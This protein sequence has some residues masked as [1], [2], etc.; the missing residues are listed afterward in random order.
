[1][2]KNV[3]ALS[4]TAAIAGFAGNALAITGDYAGAASAMAVSPGGVG[5]NL[6]VPYFSAQNG[7]D[8]YLNITN[9]DTVNGK[10]VKVR[11]R[12]AANS[13]DVFDFQVFLSPGDIWAAALTNDE[14]G[15]ARLVTSDK[16]CTL[17]KGIS[18]RALITSRVDASLAEADK[19]LAVKEGYIE[20][21]TMANIPPAAAATSKAVATATLD[22]ATN[23]LYQATKHSSAGVPTCADATMNLLVNNPVDVLTS[24]TANTLFAAE[25]LGMTY[26][27]AS[28]TASWAVVNVNNVVTWSGV[29]NAMTAVD[30][31]GAP[32]TGN[33]VFWPQTN[34]RVN[35]TNTATT[36]DLYT[37]DALYI[38]GGAAAATAGATAP[39]PITGPI[40]QP[41]YWDLP[42]LSTP[43]TSTNVNGA[44][45]DPELQAEEV[46]NLLAVSSV[47]NEY[48]I[49]AG[50]A[51]QT[52][53]VM[54]MP[55]RRYAVAVDYGTA[56]AFT[57]RAIYNTE[58][59]THFD[60]TNAKLSGRTV[61]VRGATV[62]EP[63]Y[64]NREEGYVRTEIGF[65]VSP[66][67]PDQLNNEV[68]LCG[69]AAVLNFA[70][71]GG[72]GGTSP[73]SA[74]VAKN[75]LTLSSGYNAGWLTVNTPGLG[76]GV[77]LLG[78]AAVKAVNGPSNYGLT[79]GH[80]SGL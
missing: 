30:T 39:S 73:L 74:A 53:W 66:G 1:M 37:A 52:D 12:G 61:C 35:A 40:V 60:F 43:Y 72:E 64:W 67:V 56:T 34:V 3:I 6:V 57:A 32:T 68:P 16:S 13:D 76:A 41:L 79:W 2:K 22:G 4:V 59:D 49:E 11:F 10:A 65:D 78:Y 70:N 77:P 58:L 19:A 15:V 7:N 18:G 8:T 9:T 23:K 36:A 28:I 50:I 5:H 62:A 14:N 26:P 20:I 55:T 48:V 51:A 80:R 63:G 31:A 75:T 45:T 21:I 17:P 47:T 29:A 54:S 38:Y 27:T 25:D 69:E 46:A 33:L 71:L 42:D 44:V 24:G